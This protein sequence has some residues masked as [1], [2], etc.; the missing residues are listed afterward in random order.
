LKQF[1]Y[2]RRMGP[3]GGRSYACEWVPYPVGWQGRAASREAAPGTSLATIPLLA[4][5]VVARNEGDH[6]GACLDAVLG[7][8]RP[9][10][11]TRVVVVDSDSDDDTG[12]VA[13]QRPVEIYR[14]RGRPRSAAAGRC[15]GTA[16]V[17]ARYVL[18][19]DGD[20]EIAAAWL[21]S[22]ISRLESNPRAAVT[23]GGR[24]NVDEGVAAAFV[25]AATTNR[26]SLGGNAL[27]RRSALVEVGGFNPYLRAEEEGELLARLC[28]AGFPHIA[29]TDLMCTHHAL[30]KDTFAGHW[31]RC[32]R[33]MAFGAGQVL[34]LAVAD[35]LVRHHAARLNRY[36][37]ALVFLATGAATA[38]A[39][40]AGF[41]I[42][43]VAM[44][45]GSGIAA[46]ALLWLRRRRLRSAVYLATEWLIGSIGLVVGLLLPR[47][48]VGAF[49]PIV[50]RLQPTRA[51]RGQIGGAV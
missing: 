45:L 19:V 42:W 41:G 46:F 3:S 29:T 20:C 22:A 7:A 35:G 9:Y 49:A 4:V 40:V 33:G 26:V 25:S 18:F 21:P 50:E 13:A 32:T 6:I 28:A 23:Y 8:V 43:P 16:L 27:Y 24:R 44:W 48:D 15:V 47:R 36:L 51:D 5:V 17:S 38:C 12:A 2:D 1:N 14:Y 31:R 30:P 34:R 39:A 37:M 11:G 10:A